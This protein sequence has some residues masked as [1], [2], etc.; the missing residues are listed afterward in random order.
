M[1]K[2][3]FTLIELMV[4]VLI[5]SIIAALVG[6]TIFKKIGKS[7]RVA[8]K[9]QIEMFGTALDG[10]RLDND[11]YPSTEQGLAALTG[12]PTVSPIPKHWEEPYLKKEIPLDP[13]GNSYV[14]VSPGQTN[15]TTYD[16]LSY[17]ADGKEGGE[18]ETDAEDIVSWK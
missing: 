4:V 3:G 2:K 10:Y 7:K 12:K 1:N 13:W 8:A 17:G 5:I 15:P 14:Y 18:K 9:A 11:E 6:P 16:L